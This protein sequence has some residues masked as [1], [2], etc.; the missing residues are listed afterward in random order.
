MPETI[1]TDGIT[2][3]PGIEVGHYTDLAN[4]TG[5][6]VVICRRGAM[7]GVDVR[8][9]FP[10]TR[11]TDMLSPTK[12]DTQIHAIT[13]TGGSVYG[14]DAASGVVR[15]LA[16]HSIGLRVGM[17][18]IP[19]VPAAVIYDLALV[20]HKVRPTAENGYA[21]CENASSGPVPEGTVGAGTGGTAGKLLGLERA[22]KSGIGTASAELEDGLIAAALV[23]TNPVGGV[24][25]PHTGQVVAGPRTEDGTMRDSITLLTSP[26]FVPPKWLPQS[27]TTIGVVATNA[28]L[29]K[30]E[31][32]RLASAAHDG[33]ALTVRPAHLTHDGDTMFALATGAYAGQADMTRLCAAVARCTSEAIIRSVR[34]ATGL[35]GI[36]AVSELGR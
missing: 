6:T 17:A 3:V 18:R 24:N 2:R 21:A 35:G 15:Y 32:N 8:G 26:D 29:T 22:M 13:L 23:V 20:T 25:D 19:R 28:R 31:V 9:N 11:E 16:E 30:E 12:W 27:N 34:K 10:A 5:C 36:P 7:G 33:L 4:A 1:A 14:L